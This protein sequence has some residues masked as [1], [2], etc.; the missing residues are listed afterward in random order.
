M[1]ERNFSRVFTREMGMSPQRFIE[2]ARLEAARRWLTG[3]NLPIDSIARRAGYSSGE[4]F[5]QAFKK[6]MLTTPGDYRREARERVS[7]H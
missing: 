1:S 7:E 2:T 4:H 3:T 6:V 5:A